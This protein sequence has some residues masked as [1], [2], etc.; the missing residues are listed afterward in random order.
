MDNLSLAFKSMKILLLSNHT[1]CLPMVQALRQAKLLAGVACGA[2]KI[3]LINKIKSVTGGTK[4]LHKLSSDNWEQK[5]KQL[6]K[7]ERPTLVFVMTF[8]H[9]IPA[10]LL[11]MPSLGFV[12]FHP[13]PLPKYRGPDPVFWQIKN[14]ETEGTLTL[15]QMDKNYD[16][17]PVISSGQFPITDS[18]THSR[19]MSESGMM[20]V[21]LVSN[22]LQV[23]NSLKII[24]SQAQ[25]MAEEKFTKRPK[26]KD[27]TIDWKNQSG[28]EILSLV[29][30]CNSSY[31]GAITDLR[32]QP[33]QILQVSLVNDSTDAKA[34]TLV[35]IGEE[36]GVVVSTKD[37][38]LISIDIVQ[39]GE[40]IMT[41]LKFTKMAQLK[42]GERF[43]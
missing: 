14:R 35:D 36:N 42:K 41:G 34:G 19:F 1:F 31:G 21:H 30:A 40:G 7:R 32:N 20:A 17:G 38:K 29:N 9:K 11:S 5:M 39:S 15:H 3:D 12:N 24:P 23:Y 26:A 4:L 27:L 37:G 13:G 8:K 22:M 18:M 33:L 25:S 16:T 2:H 10:S 6:L 43:L 28:A